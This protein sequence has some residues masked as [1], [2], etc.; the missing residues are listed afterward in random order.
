MG[1]R[2]PV[3]TCTL[4]CVEARDLALGE[5]SVGGEGGRGGANQTRSSCR[6]VGGGVGDV[7]GEAVGDRA[8]ERGSDGAGDGEGEDGANRSVGAVDGAR[9]SEGT[10]GVLAGP[11]S[12]AG[13]SREY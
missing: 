11:E 6:A 4:A 8:G 5:R 1:A 12:A 2:V 10:T 7:R 9:V 13:R 3:G